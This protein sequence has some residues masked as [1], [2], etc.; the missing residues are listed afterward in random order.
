MQETNDL[1]SLIPQSDEDSSLLRLQT[2]EEEEIN[3][4]ETEEDDDKT[5]TKISPKEILFDDDNVSLTDNASEVAE[6][7]HTNDKEEEGDND[8]D[9]TKSPSDEEDQSESEAED[10]PS[11]KPKKKKSMP[12][13]PL[14]KTREV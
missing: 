5:G 3:L 8:N 1:Q 10:P 7:E 6:E 12:I 14:A 13:K 11:P 2:A 9:D 4:P